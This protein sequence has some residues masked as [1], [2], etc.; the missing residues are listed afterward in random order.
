MS[1]A[2]PSKGITSPLSIEIDSVTTEESGR[3]SAAWSV[4]CG[5]RD[6]KEVD[7]RD[8]GRRHSPG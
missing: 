1:A 8:H 6:S 7:E 2:M 5:A 3:E 4:D